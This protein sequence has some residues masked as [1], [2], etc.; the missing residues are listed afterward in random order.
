M[1]LCIIM[2]AVNHK[3]QNTCNGCASIPKTCLYTLC[4]EALIYCTVHSSVSCNKFALSTWCTYMYI[5]VLPTIS[6][7]L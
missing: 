5:Q 2:S 3:L 4:E 6:L 7:C 1:D